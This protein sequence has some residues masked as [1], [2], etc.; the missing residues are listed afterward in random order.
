MTM[1]SKENV[2]GTMASRAV[3]APY[4][5]PVAMKIDDGGCPRLRGGQS[6]PEATEVASS[7]VK[8]A[9]GED[10]RAPEWILDQGGAWWSGPLDDYRS[11][12]DSDQK[13]VRHRLAPAASAAAAEL[14][15]VLGELEDPPSWVW[16]EVPLMDLSRP[17]AGGGGRV[18]TGVVRPD[19]LIHTKAGRI[20]LVDMKVSAAPDPGWC[21]SA[22][23]GPRRTLAGFREW[24]RRL[25]HVPGIGEGEVAYWVLQVTWAGILPQ[26]GAPE[27]VTAKRVVLDQAW[28]RQHR[29]R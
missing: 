19:L 15:W 12:S 25:R 1:S 8:A 20:I 5:K 23:D 18:G 28:R 11:L 3:T 2:L 26:K 10:A 13:W 22:H 7:W 16:S 6:I 24:E 14:D 21:A 27:M 9:L 17:M 29:L 4:A